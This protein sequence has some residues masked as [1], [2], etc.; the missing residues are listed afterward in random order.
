MSHKDITIIIT[1]FKS[2][3]KI[4]KC[5]N[6][7]GEDYK[8]LV[9][10]NSNNKD[11]K[12]S[13]EKKFKNVQCI[14]TGENIGYARSNNLALKTVTTK[15]SLI[16]NPDTELEA[17]CLNN[18]FIR[19][20]KIENKFSLIGPILHQDKS[21]YENKSSNKVDLIKVSNIKGFG[22]FINM[23]KIKKIDFFDENFFLF[24][25]E[26]DLCDRLKKIGE[27]IFIDPSLKIFHE[28]GSSSDINLSKEI[29]IIKNWHWT[30]STF[31]YHKKHKNFF[32]AMIIVFPKFI[33]SFL[34]MIF[35]FLILRKTKSIIYYYRLNGFVNAILGKTSWFR[36]RKQLMTGKFN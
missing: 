20:K 11:F 33:S 32:L 25:E 9:V 36:G 12:T 8:I 6:S 17:N 14:L 30:W 26:I 16:L 29:N 28:G 23:E 21:F 2:D 3:Q 10:E 22:I 31:Y 24:F 19:V 5:L 13:I 7:I 1:T 4:S 18:F 35:N 27:E 15:F 34:K